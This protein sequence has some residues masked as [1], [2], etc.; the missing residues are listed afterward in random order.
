[1][2]TIRLKVSTYSDAV[3]VEGVFRGDDEMARAMYN[4]CRKYF[5]EHYKGVFFVGDDHKEDIFQEAFIA[6]WENIINRKIY[7]DE[8]EVF[9][10]NGKP[11]S[12]KLTTYFMSI[13]RLKNLEWVRKQDSFL[14]SLEELRGMEEELKKM[15]KELIYGGGD[16][17]NVI[18]IMIDIIADCI[19]H[20][21]ERCGQ[22]INMFYAEEKTLDEILSALPTFKSKDALKTAKNKCMNNLKR[23]AQAVYKDYLLGA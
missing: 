18:G 7:V 14:G 17:E 13:A 1:M 16:E 8:G 11:F 5:D 12:G 15:Y 6:L 23:S 4:H 2:A 9:G 10:Q 20:M 22:I 3:Y 21:S 19:S